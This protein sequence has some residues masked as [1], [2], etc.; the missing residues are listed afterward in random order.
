MDIRLKEYNYQLPKELI[1]REP[2]PNARLMVANCHPDGLSFQHTTVSQ[3]PKY[4][5]DYTTV[6]NDATCRKSYLQGIHAKTNQQVEVV[7]TSRVSDSV[8]TVIT[9]PSDRDRKTHEIYF[10]RGQNFMFG[11][12]LGMTEM[13]GRVME[14][15]ST[16]GITD[17]INSIA[18]YTVP[19]YVVDQN[20]YM[21]IMQWCAPKY[22]TDR[23]AYTNPIGT[24]AE[25]LLVSDGHI[26]LNKRLKTKA[27][28]QPITVKSGL[29]WHR[30][31]RVQILNWFHDHES[32]IYEIP[33]PT[34]KAAT[35]S[36]NV[37]AIGVEVMRAIEMSTH[38]GIVLKGQ[39]ETK[40][41]YMYPLRPNK[42][43]ALLSQFATP[44]SKQLLAQETLVGLNNLQAIYKEAIKQR[45]RFLHYGDSLLILNKYITTDLMN[46]KMF[47]PW[48][49]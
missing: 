37:A 45:Y 26:N 34:A 18:E 24:K 14:F 13:R 2:E 35:V 17:A 42:V 5:S 11:R 7:L 46:N 9:E 19:N 49:K 21:P 16:V 15:K 6:Y 36:K 48:V 23:T 8:Y 32:E 33:E 29:F 47:K 4:L 20:D 44:C 28:M 3:L 25:T 22:T 41:H 12:I 40:E 1:A 10:N 39:A 27:N 31:P 30:D 38:S 43:N